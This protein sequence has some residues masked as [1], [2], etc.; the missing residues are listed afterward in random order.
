MR[1][2]MRN[3]LLWSALLGLASAA[4]AE[5]LYRWT[6]AEGVVAFSDDLKRIPE[7]YRAGAVRMETANL[8][9]YKRFTPATPSQD[10]A[11]AKQL[12]E[13]VAR[14]RELNAGVDAERAAAEAP[15]APSEVGALRVNGKLSLNLQGDP[16]ADAGPI[17]VEEHR[18]RTGSATTHVYVVRQGDKILSVV[19]PHTNESGAN[20]PTFEEVVGEDD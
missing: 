8:S 9:E 12:S 14:L 4:N 7:A 18:V 2:R 5:T 6:N 1:M 10:E 15:A 3:V 13:Q 19:R 11:Y 16:A 20:F 17:V